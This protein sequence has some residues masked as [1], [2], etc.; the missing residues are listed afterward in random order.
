MLLAGCPDAGKQIEPAVKPDKPVVPEKPAKPVVKPA[1]YSFTFGVESHKMAF[2]KGGTYTQVVIETNKPQ[3]DARAITYASSDNKI[4]TVDNK[5]V[6]TF[7]TWG[8]VTITATKTAV[9]GLPEEATASYILTIAP[10]DFAFGGATVVSRKVAFTA[11]TYSFTVDNTKRPQ[12]DKRAITYASSEGKIAT[13]DNKGVVTFVTPGTVTITAT[14]TAEAGHAET[15]ASYILYITMKPATKAELVAEIKRATRVHGNEVDLNYIDTADITDMSWLFGSYGRNG[16]GLNKFNGDISK[17]D[18]SNVT[19]M[20]AI[21][22]YAKL[23]NG[24][25]SEW[26]VSNVTNMASMFY[27]AKAFNGDISKWEVS[28]VTRMPGMFSGATKFNRDISRWNVSQVT[29][30]YAMFEGAAAFNQDISRW[31]VLKV[32]KM[33]FMF[34]GA[35]A[36]NQDISRWNVARVINMCGMFHNALAFDQNISSWDVSNVTNTSRM[37]EGATAFNGDISEWQVSNVTNMYAM[38]HKARAFDGDISKWDVSN[39]TTMQGMFKGATAFNGNIS[40]WKVGKVT[41]MYSM[42]YGA[43]AFNQDISR[44]DVSK[45][46]DM[47]YMFQDA[48]SFDQDISGWDVSQV[49]TMLQMFSRA[50]AFKQNLDAWGERLNPAIRANS[51][52]SY[53]MFYGSGLTYN[54]PSWCKNRFRCF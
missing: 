6:V 23:F 19:N 10:P 43:T 15:T 24:D 34:S 48:T 27:R 1:P 32:T 8:K 21:F 30:M 44:W 31:K 20:Y 38:F 26:Q 52:N 49:T 51:D 35:A 41:N 50:K 5:G 47:N 16:Y 37:F 33:H 11:S 17:W 2:T 46:T 4:A 25:I 42:F 54:L 12:G 3:G 22:A 9:P 7:V 40:S 28:K 36:F 39:V 14:K 18:V 53:I 29:T 13:V 45:V